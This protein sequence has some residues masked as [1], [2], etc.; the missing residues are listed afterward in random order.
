MKIYTKTGD[1]GSTSLFGGD[2]LYKNNPRVDAYGDLD[3]LNSFIG[4]LA[5]GIFEDEDADTYSLLLSIQDQLFVIGSHLATVDEKYVAKLPSISEDDITLLE[6]SIDLYNETLPAMTH[7]VLPGGDITAS[8]C[9]VAR[10]V[11]RRAERAIVGLSQTDTIDPIFIKY[12]NRL[13]DYLFV[14]SR[15]IIADKE[16]EERLWIPKSK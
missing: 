5:D 15:K 9:H 4:L 14:L 8:Y 3:E 6:S 1:N 2:R 16:K 7:F 12:L 10:T 11:C 13:S